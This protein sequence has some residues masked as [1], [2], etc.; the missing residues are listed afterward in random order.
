M[1]KV[2]NWS[3]QSDFPTCEISCSRSC[4]DIEIYS[5]I[6][7]M[8]GSFCVLSIVG[9]TILKLK[10]TEIWLVDQACVVGLPEIWY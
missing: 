6:G 3:G 7:F 10:F 1:N 8:S 5:K 2:G 4:S 9:R